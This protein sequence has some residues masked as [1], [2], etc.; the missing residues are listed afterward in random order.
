MA[1]PDNDLVRCRF[2]T[3]AN[4]CGGA[5]DGSKHVTLDQVRDILIEVQK[6]NGIHASITC[7]AVFLL[8]NI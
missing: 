2:A 6:K 4:E 3:G 8:W 1:D 5:C 7:Q